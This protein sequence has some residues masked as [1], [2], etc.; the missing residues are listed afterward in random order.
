MNISPI[1][2]GKTVKFVGIDAAMAAEVISAEL[3]IQGNKQ[4]KT[5]GDSFS[6]FA[7]RAD[8]LTE[9][10]VLISPQDKKETHELQADNQQT[11]LI[12]NFFSNPREGYI[13]T[14]D[15]AKTAMQMQSETEA[16][17]IEIR[18]KNNFMGSYNTEH[19]EIGEKVYN[20]Q[21]RLTALGRATCD[22][23]IEVEFL[24]NKRPKLDFKI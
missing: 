11:I 8:Y 7:A 3:E 5:S 6:D 9:K 20:L 13:L 14:G 4:F 19:S 21:K 12:Y 23:V 15:D 10:A 22:Q 18:R 16:E 2:F 1:S 24:H 17:I